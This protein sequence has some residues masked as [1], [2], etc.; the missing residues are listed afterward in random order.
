MTAV[1]RRDAAAVGL[2]S[3]LALAGVV[4]FALLLRLRQYV[5]G[6][7]LWHDEAM[8]AL[9]IREEDLVDLVTTPLPRNQVAPFGFLLLE[10]LMTVVSDADQWL[11]LV[12]LAAS[13]LLVWLTWRFAG[14][15]R[16]TAARIVLLVTVTW[17]PVL[18]YYGS[19]LKQYGVDATAAMALLLAHRQRRAHPV[20]LIAVG[21]AAVLVSHPAIIVLAAICL[22]LAVEELRAVGAVAAVRRLRWPIVVWGVTAALVAMQIRR[23]SNAGD[24]EFFWADG[25]APLPRSSESLRWWWDSALGLVHL[26][27]SLR[28]I[29]S[30]QRL[31][32]WTEP[33]IVVSLVVVVIAV[34]VLARFD[35]EA[36]SLPLATLAITLGLA[37]FDIYPFRG[38][39]ILFLIPVVALL[40]AHAVDQL[41][42]RLP[43]VA[44]ATAMLVVVQ[45]G[46]T[47]GDVLVDPDDRFDIV[48]A[49]GRLE[50]EVAPGDVV[51]LGRGTQPAFDFYADDYD[52]AG[53]TLRAVEV[54]DAEAVRSRGDG[55]TVWLLASHVLGRDLADIS[56][57]DRAPGVTEV[58]TGDGV[59]L[60]RFSPMPESS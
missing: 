17:S 53:A 44:A 21:V 26:T 30:Q 8:L 27:S 37:G 58:W 24:I 48:E 54:Y 33:L 3:R 5:V 2:G 41:G 31:D 40:L 10:K 55:T 20:R 13:I 57:M 9:G 50:R 32:E 42:S 18:V 22:V 46:W 60:R 29:A 52:L 11:R 14:E 45:F 12:P 16:T 38:R 7:A 36:L 25:F 35:R 34:V 4:G 59:I 47:S 23:T 6:R 43:A 39:L 56:E 49:L 1:S 15:L 28:G 19:E 51:V